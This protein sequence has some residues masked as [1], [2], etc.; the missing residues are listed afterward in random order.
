MKIQD[1]L[2][3]GYL[4][5]ELPPVFS[6]L[7]FAS[8]ATSL[9][10]VKG[11]YKSYPTAVN[12]ARPGSVVRRLAIPNPLSQ[13]NL[14][15]KCIDYW[16]DIKNHV[17]KSDLS[18]SRPVKGNKS[19]RAVGMRRGFDKVAI[20]RVRRLTECRY[21]LLSDIS[22]CYGSIY[23]HSIEWAATG[24]DVAKAALSNKSVQTNFGSELDKAI[25]NTQDGQTKGIA[26]GPD[27]SLIIA[28]IVL[29]SVD[30]M[31]QKTYPDLGKYCFRIIDDFEY[32][33]HTYDEAEEMLLAWQLALSGMELSVNPAKTMIV[34]GPPVLEEAWHMEL[35]RFARELVESKQRAMNFP[36]FF[37]LAFEASKMNPK[38]PVLNFAAATAKNIVR[39][40]NQDTW[41]VLLPLMLLSATNEPTCL[42]NV[43]E[44]LNYAENSGW[45]IDR[46]AVEQSLNA[47]SQVHARRQHGT[48]VA[49]CLWILYKCD[50][51]VHERSAQMIVEMSDNCALLLLH[52]MDLEKKVDGSDIDFSS[53]YRRAEATEAPTR[54]DWLLSYELALQGVTSDSEFRKDV[55]WKFMLDNKVSFIDID[56]RQIRS[57]RIRRT[58]RRGPRQMGTSS[59]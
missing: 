57:P 13:Y 1:L 40:S 59:W 4:P 9:P 23:T 26:I 7:E 34:E 8:I 37:H 56:S 27:T 49:W 46:D 41:D 48:V 31:L 52:L 44:A 43:Y 20:E 30:V 29:C 11:S 47:I 54:E 10:K 12:L 35:T 42:E 58:P 21:T 6:S 3:R 18:L 51:R 24:K 55:N 36:G 53:T 45:N 33:G 50:L 19:E 16:E 25:R 17:R 14:A 5:K 2:G 39:D 15:S 28:E 38:D 32:Y 22:E